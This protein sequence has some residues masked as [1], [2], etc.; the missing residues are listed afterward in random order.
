M[1]ATTAPETLT[2]LAAHQTGWRIA[3]RTGSRWWLAR[4]LLRSTTR[5]KLINYVS[6]QRRIKNILKHL[7]QSKVINHTHLIQTHIEAN[8]RYL[9]NTERKPAPTCLR[10]ETVPLLYRENL[11]PPIYRDITVPHVYRRNASSLPCKRDNG[12]CCIQGKA[13]SHPFKEEKASPHVYRRNPSP[14]CLK[15]ERSHPFKE[16]NSPLCI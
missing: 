12:P 3:R 16:E 14:K 2:P 7:K 4:H 10:K 15:R 13:S 6:F 8:K 9:S 1:Y 11:I 5:R